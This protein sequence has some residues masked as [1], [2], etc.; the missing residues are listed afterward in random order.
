HVFGEEG[1]V[2]L[3]ADLLELVLLVKFPGLVSRPVKQD[4]AITAHAQLL[5]GL[6]D[7]GGISGEDGERDLESSAFKEPQQGNDVF[8]VPLDAEDVYQLAAGF[9]VL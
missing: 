1:L 5:V 7:L 9:G 8:P 6:S 4:D 3:T 2:A